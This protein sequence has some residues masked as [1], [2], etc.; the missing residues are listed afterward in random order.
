MADPKRLISA[1]A[2][3]DLDREFFRFLEERAGDSSAA[4]AG[5]LLSNRVIAGDTCLDLNRIAGKPLGD[6]LLGEETGT[7]DPLL[8]ER[9]P[10]LKQWKSSLA[11]SRIAAPPGEMAPLILDPSGR[12]Y[13]Y[14]YWRY[15]TRLSENIKGR[16]HL[17]PPRIDEGLLAAGLRRLFPSGEKTDWQRVAALRA[18]T[19]RFTVISGGPGTGKTTTVAK[20]ITLLLEQARAE[21]GKYTIAL[22]APTGKAAAR[23]KESIDRAMAP[24]ETLKDTAP[25]IL[26]EFPRE[27][28]TIHRLLGARPGTPYFRHDASSPLPFDAVVVDESSMV[29]LALMAKLLDA[30]P[31]ESRVILLGDKDQLASVEAGSVLGDICGGVDRSA[32][33]FSRSFATLAKRLSGDELPIAEAG[34]A[35]MRDTIVYLDKSYRFNSDI[36]RLGR[37]IRAGRAADTVGEL[38]DGGY[39]TVRLDPPGSLEELRARV[40]DLASKGP[41]QSLGE[42]DPADALNQ[43]F[44]VMVLCALRRGPR[45]AESINKIIESRIAPPRRQGMY[46]GR[47]VMITNN[48]YSLGLFNGDIGIIRTG[49]GGAFL[50]HFPGGEPKSTRSVAAARLPLHETVYSLTVHKS[51][52]SEFSRVLLVLPD[53]DSP[54]LTRELLYTAVT[55]AR[56]K[57]EIWGDPKV[58]ARAIERPV[59]RTSG[60]RFALW[61]D[62]S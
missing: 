26:Q 27:A 22:A 40:A 49:S 11:A 13:L 28:F 1:E 54:V 45:G 46:N 41:W 8:A 53:R 29:D 48:S 23:L 38:S 10:A 33:C 2:F 34:D 30:V 3:S 9:L 32:P 58:L 47:P 24:G 7:S 12:L 5:A 60:L 50:A 43:F 4:L 51:Q 16:L 20:I 21:G 61:G 39:N 25:E 19:G 59:M 31:P 35:V 42:G 18:V 15:E 55:R 17:D 44:E 62:E 56:C 36:A 57:I 6:V 37:D 52:G 14:R